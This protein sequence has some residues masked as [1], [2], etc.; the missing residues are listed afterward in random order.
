[1][2]DNKSSEIPSNSFFRGELAFGEPARINFR[3]EGKIVCKGD[4]HVGED[5]VCK[6]EVE[7][8]NVVVDGQVEGNVTAANSVR[9]SAKGRI[10]GDISTPELTVTKGA[11]FVGHCSVGTDGSSSGGARPPARPAQAGTEPRQ[12]ATANK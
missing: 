2:A 12:P 11:M 7:A 5:A 4:L 3:V 9:L 1:M 10:V 8:P 6:A